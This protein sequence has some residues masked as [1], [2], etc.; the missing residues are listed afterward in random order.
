V[1]E[2]PIRKPLHDDHPSG[3]GL[4]A[5]VGVGELFVG[6]LVGDR[7]PLFVEEVVGTI[8]QGGC[9]FRVHA[10]RLSRIVLRVYEGRLEHLQ[11][12]GHDTSRLEGHRI[13][14]E[15]LPRDEFHPQDQ[16]RAAVRD[17]ESA[18]E[19]VIPVSKEESDTETGFS[20]Q[21]K[22]QPSL[23]QTVSD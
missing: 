14:D 5:G 15:A 13:A 9:G 2:G 23:H 11:G 19:F 3:E 7:D 10:R 4:G 20:S 18:A 22:L 8:R 1:D 12:P 21:A 6:L 16:L 17:V